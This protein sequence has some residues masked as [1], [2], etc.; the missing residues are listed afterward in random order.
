M[1]CWRLLRRACSSRRQLGGSSPRGLGHGAGCRISE[2][3]A[4]LM[5]AIS[6]RQRGRCAC[7]SGKAGGAQARVGTDIHRRRMFACCAHG[8]ASRQVSAASSKWLPSVMSPQC[9]QLR[10]AQSAWPTQ[11]SQVT[12][13]K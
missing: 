7:A 8:R 6:R 4:S 9:C 12:A 1:Q 10:A 13:A 11:C 5:R 3:G 2:R